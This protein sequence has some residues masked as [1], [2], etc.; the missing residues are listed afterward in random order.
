MAFSNRKWKLT[1]IHAHSL[2][3][4]DGES[5]VYNNVS[6]DTHLMGFLATGLL[7]V[8]RDAPSDSI[9]LSESLGPM[10]QAETAEQFLLQIEQVLA[11]LHALALIEPL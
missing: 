8:L 6:G 7:C 4:W 11:D 5:V 10:R 9:S 3:R 2:R 1:S